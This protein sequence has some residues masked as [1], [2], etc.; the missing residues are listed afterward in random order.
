MKIPLE[1]G[2]SNFIIHKVELIDSTENYIMLHKL[3]Q[4]NLCRTPYS[5]DLHL[6]IDR[7]VNVEVVRK[8]LNQTNIDPLES[9][10]NAST[11]ADFEEHIKV[12]K[13][14]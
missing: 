12:K 11:H 14:L 4:H 10:A 3:L 2:K 6:S 1:R 5:R 8:I 13:I 7:P 9:V